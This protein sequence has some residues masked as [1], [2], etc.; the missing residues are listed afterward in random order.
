MFLMKNDQ[1]RSFSIAVACSGHANYL[2]TIQCS[3]RFQNEITLLSHTVFISHGTFWHYFLKPTKKMQVLKM[4]CTGSV[5]KSWDLLEQRFMKGLY[6]PSHASIKH[7]K[8]TLL[9]LNK[10]AAFGAVYLGAKK[11]FLRPP[12]AHTMP[13]RN[14]TNAARL[15]ERS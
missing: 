14:R 11:A 7:N 8:L 10:P 5:W 1:N 12:T 4:V 13:P 9:S 6:S 15:N 2:F 3:A